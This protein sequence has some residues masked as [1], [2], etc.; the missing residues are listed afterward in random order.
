LTRGRRRVGLA[1]GALFAVG[2]ALA[3]ASSCELVV[4]LDE[5]Q[6]KKCAADHKLCYGKCVPKNNPATGC[7]L[8]TCAPCVFPNATASCSPTEACL[9]AS[10]VGDYLS[11]KTSA[12]DTDV[13]HDPDN[14]SA[15]NVVC[16][17][18]P[19]VSKRGCSA[20]AC[21]VR[22]CDLGFEDCNRDYRDGC[23]TSLL[24]DDMNCGHC[25]DACPAGQTCQNGVCG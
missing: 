19:H 10:C 24:D 8:S 20:R 14:C 2:V 11:C 21:A 9:I 1:L 3:L 12:C 18:K 17:P 4:S 13:A 22:G 23:E 15:C 5:L 6:D 25:G 16:P 7:S